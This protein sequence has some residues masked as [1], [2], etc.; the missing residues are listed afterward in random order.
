M[1]VGRMPEVKPVLF[2]SSDLMP[3]I[4]EVK[5]TRR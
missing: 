1:V 5:G 4:K 3:K 2:R